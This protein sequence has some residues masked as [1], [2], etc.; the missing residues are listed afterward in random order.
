MRYHHICMDG[1]GGSLVAQRVAEIY[2]ALVEQRSVPVNRFGSCLDLLGE[3]EKYQHT[4][5]ARDRQYWLAATAD[6]PDVITLSG[7]PPAKSRAILRRSAFIPESLLK[8]LVD[9]GKQCGASLAQVVEAAAAL[10]LHRFTGAEEVVLG[11]PVTA[12][13]G[14]RTRSTPGLVSNVLPLRI[15]F[16]ACMS[17][18]DLL[19]QVVKRKSELLRHQRYRAEDLRRDLGLHPADPDIHGMTVNVMSFDYNLHF[20]GCTATTHNLSNGPVDEL[21]IIL[22]DRRDGS[23]PRL[24]FDANPAHYTQAELTAHQQR[25]LGLLQQLAA[26]ERPVHEFNLLLPDEKPSMISGFHTP[27]E[28]LGHATLTQWFE[29]QVARTPD[30]TAMVSR[31]VELTYCGLNDRANRL[32]RYLVAMGAGPETLVG[33]CLPRTADML[34][35]L[36]SILKSGSAYLPL[37][38]EYPQ[39]RLVG[40]MQDANALCV[41]TTNSLASLFSEN[42][43]KLLLDSRELE[44]ALAR[45]PEHNLSDAERSSQLLPQHPA[46][47]IHTSGSTGKPKGVVIEHY[48]AAA[49]IRWAGSVFTSDEWAGVLASTSISFDLSVFE[50]FATLS[51]GGTV[52]LAGSSLELSSLPARNRVRLINTVPSAARSLLDA[53]GLPHSVC[54]VNLAGEALPKA[55]VDDLYRCG[56]IKRVFNL[57]GPSEDTTY[58][59]FALCRPHDQ[60][61]PG[62]GSPVWN[63]RAYVLDCYLQPLSPGAIGELYLS[64]AGLARGYL[65]RPSLTAERFVADPFSPG[66]RMYRTGDLAR[67]RTDGTLEFL[68]RADHQVKIRGF[69]I[70]PGE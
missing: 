61:E 42:T 25:F 4:Q 52:L 34:V 62:I 15:C 46:Y 70:E 1:Y 5:L 51:H 44:D 18:A 20:S 63:T 66:S 16:T 2:S 27:D 19:R 40:I 24:D 67:V 37:D 12:R 45:T 22:Y 7:K 68:G 47:V 23:A 49:F 69:R 55:M 10:Y 36:L 41:L 57:Y 26:V 9:S 31:E 38:P 33:I 8:S 64:G 43:R 53:A 11:V 65:N 50:L 30:A 14:R 32:A 54:T 28:S 58:S 48:S 39:A 60:A 21:S 56:H 59:T 29:A 35:G 6:R 3:E 13:A 17:F